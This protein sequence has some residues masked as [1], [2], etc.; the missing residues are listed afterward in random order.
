MGTTVIADRTHF[1]FLIMFHYLFPILTMGL[2]VL[3]AVLK[4][5]QLVTKDDR[6]ARAA[7]F[8]GRIFALNFGAGV[9]TGVPM[10]FQ[11]GTNWAQFSTYS[12]GIIGQGLMMEGVYAFFAESAF[13][14]LFLFGEKRV[15]LVVHW[16]S[17]VMVA[18]GTL[19]SG[20][21]I[22]M[23][24]AFMQHP[25][26]YKVGSDG[27]LHLTSL[28]GVMTNPYEIWEYW[29]TIN[30]ALVTGAFVMTALGAYYL[31]AEKHQDFARISLRIGVVAGIIFS[32]TQLFPTGDKNGEN[33]VKYNPVKLAAMEGLF[34]TEKGAPLSIIG[35]PDTH[36][37]TLLDPIYVP[38]IL[39]YLTYGNFK[40][41]VRG[42]DDYPRDLWPPM[43]VTY[44]AYHIMVGLGTIFIGEMAIAAFL[45]W[46]GALF[47][48]RWFLWILMLS[49]PF[50]YIANEAG[51]VVTE[52]GRQPWLIVGLMRTA[53]GYSANVSAGEVI[54]TLLGFAGLYAALGLVFL[55]LVLRFIAQGPEEP[56]SQ[57]A[58]LR[59]EAA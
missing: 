15:P 21:F 33:V 31:L 58:Q 22:T 9:A 28:W 59:E 55:Y 47:K 20:Y 48:Q 19:L 49:V 12:G 23:T 35:M 53:Q 25:V 4:T 43:E 10:E 7:R 8:W 14:G 50:P 57:K 54:F 5:F 36:R 26:A 29:H 2:S 41:S 51:W 6:Y 17:S 40:A 34:H 27:M 38:G 3:I 39:S 46:R 13:L 37:G 11:F 56:N 44:Y 24:D 32:V 45:L 1:A 42:L 16:F 30:G 52:V 18:V